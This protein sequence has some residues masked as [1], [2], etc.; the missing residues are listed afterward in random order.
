MD[1]SRSPRSATVKSQSTAACRFATPLSGRALA[2]T[3]QS[4]GGKFDIARRGAAGGADRGAA[5]AWSNS[6]M[7]QIIQHTEIS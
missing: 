4:V 6:G 1:R 3:Q 5:R 7:Y 2:G